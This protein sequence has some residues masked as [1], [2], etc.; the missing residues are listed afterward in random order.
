MKAD[1]QCLLKKIDDLIAIGNESIKSQF[2]LNHWEQAVP[3]QLFGKFRAGS[4]S[5]LKMVFGESH[6]LYKDFDQRI[7]HNRLGTA[8]SGVGIMESARS[9]VEDGWLGT[10]RGVIAAD[11]FSNFLEMSEHFLEQ[12]YKDP[13]AVMIGSV[14]EEHLREL[15]TRNSIP[16]VLTQKDGGIRP[17]KADALNAELAAAGAY[18]KLDQKSITAWLDLRNKAAH[19]QY[20]EYTKEQVALMLASARDF[21]VRNAP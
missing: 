2:S 10:V 9:L 3:P 17:K 18:G 11:V 15:C 14:L 8:M 13:A 5:L 12:G 1:K 21:I 20:A 16:T 6:P 7:V 4:L 19:G